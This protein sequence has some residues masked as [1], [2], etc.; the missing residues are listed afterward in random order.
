SIFVAGAAVQWLRDALGV[1]ATAAETEGLA[2]GLADNAGVYFVPAFTGLGA[3]YWAAEAR[4]ALTGL[5]RGAGRAEIAR[6][7]LEAVAYQTADLL[8]AMARDGAPAARL[9]VDGGMV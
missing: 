3:P 9:K 8:E 5:T 2:D 1:I 4:G 6:A 7:A